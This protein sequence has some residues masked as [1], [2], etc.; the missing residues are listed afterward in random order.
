MGEMGSQCYG[1][2]RLGVGLWTQLQAMRALRPC[3]MRL[4]L[5]LRSLSGCA[6]LERSLRLDV[7]TDAELESGRS[8]GPVLRTVQSSTDPKQ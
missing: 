5:Q 1:S 4:S 6:Q 7:D 8:F 3:F 2:C